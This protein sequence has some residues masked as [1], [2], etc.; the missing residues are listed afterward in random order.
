MIGV[1]PDADLRAANL[2]GSALGRLPRSALKQRQRLE[3]GGPKPGVATDIPGDG[4]RIR[5]IPHIGQSHQKLL[6]VRSDFTDDTGVHLAGFDRR[7]HAEGLHNVPVVP[8][9]DLLR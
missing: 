7:L 8:R 2:D 4:R 3:R 9:R 6:A 5:L 1:N